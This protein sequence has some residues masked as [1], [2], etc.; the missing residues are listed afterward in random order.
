MSDFITFFGG[1][2]SAA[3]PWIS[4]QTVRQYAYKISPLDAE[5]YQRVT[6]DGTGAVDP[7]DNITDYVARTY[8]R[9]RGIPAPSAPIPN[10]QTD[11]ANWANG[12]TKTALNINSG[13]RSR[14]LQ[15]TGRG[16]TTVLGLFSG[17]NSPTSVRA[18]I[19]IDG[20]TVLDS[21]ISWGV[22]AGFVFFLGSWAASGTTLGYS[23]LPVGGIQFRRSLEVWVTPT[24]GA[25]STNGAFAHSFISEA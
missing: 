18:E 25:I 24:G 6:A 17:V 16:R 3:T 1:G 14:V 9:V 15:L 5:T 19:I 4:G 22:S 23:A 2:G 13:V 8:Q 12:A 21:T 10:G 11:P 20:R 7:A